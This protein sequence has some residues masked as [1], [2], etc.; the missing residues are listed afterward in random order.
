MDIGYR[1]TVYT[2][3]TVYTMYTVYTVYTLR[4]GALGW[5]G[6]YTLYPTPYTTTT[7]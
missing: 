6:T 2:V 3:Y 4:I 5:G 7:H 1:Y